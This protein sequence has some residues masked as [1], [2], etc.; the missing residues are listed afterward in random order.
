MFDQSDLSYSCVCSNG[1]SPNASQY[2]Q[3]IPYYECTESNTQCVNN[4]P[5]GNSA[6]QAACRTNNPCGAQDPVRV[7]LTTSSSTMAATAASTATGSGGADYTG[8][9][10]A[11]ATTSS[12]TDG[13]SAASTLAVSFG[14]TFGIGVVACGFLAGFVLI[15]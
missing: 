6:C 15:L 11:A 7:N 13:K 10:G 3:T 2:S 9:G 12:S 8:F 14:Q 5:Q 4:C 1:I